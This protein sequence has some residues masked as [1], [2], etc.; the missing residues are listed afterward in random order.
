MLNRYVKE[1][2]AMGGSGDGSRATLN[3]EADFCYPMFLSLT[4]TDQTKSRQVEMHLQNRDLFAFV[5]SSRK[6][7]LWSLVY[8]YVEIC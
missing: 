4:V 1:Q 8:N 7:F 2:L 6:V 5:F 3:F